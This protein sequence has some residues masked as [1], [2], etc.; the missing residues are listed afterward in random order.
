MPVK[1]SMK[2]GKQIASRR[3]SPFYDDNISI[4]Q[5]GDRM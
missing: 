1:P 2:R 5:F 4:A 3:V